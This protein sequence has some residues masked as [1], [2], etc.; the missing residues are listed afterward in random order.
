[1]Y[2]YFKSLPLTEERKVDAHF[3]EF[4]RYIRGAR[5]KHVLDMRAIRA[6]IRIIETKDRKIDAPPITDAK[7]MRRDF[8][9]R[10]NET[11]AHLRLF[12][13]TFFI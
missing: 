1:M 2:G 13:I 10:L 11:L 4:Q 9:A 8:L 7:V 12:H 5:D 3:T 6:L